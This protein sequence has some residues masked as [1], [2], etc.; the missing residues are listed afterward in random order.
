MKEWGQFSSIFL[1]WAAPDVRFLAYGNSREVAAEIDLYVNASK[2]EFMTFNQDGTINS[3]NG[4][5]IKSAEL[6]VY[7]G[8]Q[9]ANIL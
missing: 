3:L 5:P 2:T 6:F 8:S 7:L 4:D 9:I 1:L